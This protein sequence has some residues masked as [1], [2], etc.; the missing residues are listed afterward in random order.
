MSHIM[1][2]A[3]VSI[4]ENY[5][6]KPAKSLQKSYFWSTVQNPTFVLFYWELWSYFLTWI[7]WKATKT[8]DSPLFEVIS[9]LLKFNLQVM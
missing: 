8:E 1:L 5:S 4:D 2:S 9:K 3:L 7:H 6:W